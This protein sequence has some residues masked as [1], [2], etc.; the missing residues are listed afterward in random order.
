ME[1]LPEEIGR[2]TGKKPVT[3]DSPPIKKGEI[4]PH[5]KDL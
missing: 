3:T 5:E 1:G 4:N 2:Q